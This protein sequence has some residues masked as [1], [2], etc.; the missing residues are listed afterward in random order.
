MRTSL[1]L[2]CCWN[3]CCTGPVVTKPTEPATVYDKTVRLDLYDRTP[4]REIPWSEHASAT[5][6]PLISPI[7]QAIKILL[8]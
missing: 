4:P 2:I 7:S 1:L 8:P 6:A 5:I 3:V